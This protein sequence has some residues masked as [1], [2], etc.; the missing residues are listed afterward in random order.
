MF[1]E[2]EISALKQGINN[3][4]YNLDYSSLKEVN[5]VTKTRGVNE[6]REETLLLF[7]VLLSIALGN[8]PRC[9]PTVSENFVPILKRD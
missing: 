7:R 3:L 5:K 4:I 2:A 1:C 8:Y 6:E 9:G